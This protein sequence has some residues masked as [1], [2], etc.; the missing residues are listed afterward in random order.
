MSDGICLLCVCLCSSQFD[1]APRRGE[2]VVTRRTPD[3]FL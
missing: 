2:P 3:Y 1:P